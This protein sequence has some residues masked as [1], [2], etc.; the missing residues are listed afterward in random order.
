[1][2]GLDFWAEPLPTPEGAIW[3]NQISGAEYRWDAA[4]KLWRKTGR[5]P[6]GPDPMGMISDGVFN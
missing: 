4:A 5:Y 3:L 6:F 1:M 2:S